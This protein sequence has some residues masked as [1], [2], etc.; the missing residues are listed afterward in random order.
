M[1]HAFSLSVAPEA[2]R[3]FQGFQIPKA[4]LADKVVRYC[5]IPLNG[6]GGSGALRG[7]AGGDTCTGGAGTDRFVFFFTETGDNAMTGF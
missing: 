7:G 3:R 4:V 1:R 2:E 5:R 6:Q